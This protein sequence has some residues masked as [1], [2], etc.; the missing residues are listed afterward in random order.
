LNRSIL[1]VLSVFWSPY[2]SFSE[3]YWGVELAFVIH[4]NIVNIRENSSCSAIPNL[5]SPMQRL[6][7][8]W[9]YWGLNPGPHSL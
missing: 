8:V 7:F 4:I 9:Q 6:F 1:F 3:E 2:T 5:I